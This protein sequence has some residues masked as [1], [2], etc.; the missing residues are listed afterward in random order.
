M[1]LTIVREPGKCFIRG[2][3]RQCGVAGLVCFSGS[4]INRV[5]CQILLS[6]RDDCSRRAHKTLKATT[7]LAACGYYVRETAGKSKQ[8][9]ETAITGRTRSESYQTKFH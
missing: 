5:N 6:T 4:H 7:Q 8:S 3:V 2:S 9:R 1:H